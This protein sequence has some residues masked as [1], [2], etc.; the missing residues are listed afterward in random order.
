M[1]LEDKIY[2][3]E[4]SN[5]IIQNS[6]ILNIEN[7]EKIIQAH[8][9]SIK[10]GVDIIKT[11]TFQANR[12]KISK[13]K[14]TVEQIIK[15]AIEN[16]KK[17]NAK[18]IAINIGPIEKTKESFEDFEI[19][20]NLYKEQILCAEKYGVD[21]IYIEQ[22][23]SLIQAKAAIIASKENSNLP[24][25]CSMQLNENLKTSKGTDII[26]ISNVLSSLKIN[27]IGFNYLSKSDQ[28]IKII[29]EF[30]KY[31]NTPL[32]INP[33]IENNINLNKYE[34]IIKK[35]IKFIDSTHFIS[36]N[37]TKELCQ[38]IKDKKYKPNNA[39][40]Y[41]ATSSNSKTVFL[42]QG[43]KLIGERINPAGKNKLQ[44]SIKN[45]NYDEIIKLALKQKNEGAD[46]LDIN[47]SVKSTNEKENMVNI[48]KS[49]QSTVDIPLQIDSM[50]SEV[51]ENA[52][53]IYNGKPIINSVNGKQSSMDKIFPIAK[54]Y[55]ALIIA[56]TFDDD[57]IPKTIQKRVD[58]AEKIIKE[59]Q[60]YQINKKDLIFDTLALTALSHPEQT[61]KTLKALKIIKE[62]FKVC[63]TLGISNISFGLP[64]RKVINSTF[65]A[66]ALTNGVDVPILNTKD[67]K[68]IE[69]INAYKV[70]YNQDKNSKEFIKKYSQ[71]NNWS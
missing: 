21:M 71:K 12:L 58:I 60:K 40:E 3:L 56:L 16:A 6:E 9:N 19:I 55:G 14:Y 57:G 5:K 67:E 53:R 28:I 22:M 24:I 29:K 50:N 63:T 1:F 62:K 18:H 61:Q 10:N 20:Y 2:T 45:K 49:I 42:G 65:L 7:P 47:V 33:S 26:T 13:T 66:F 35:G 54:K 25:L 32:I 11:N 39:E 70:L 8:K 4:G 27:A 34:E 37:K 59:A 51:I 36:K 17:A 64:Y 43:L 44:N 15:S 69:T 68:I 41:T 23:S 52:V 31:T 38:Y 48:I 30:L 46:I